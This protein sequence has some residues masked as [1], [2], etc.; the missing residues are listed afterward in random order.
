MLFSVIL[1]ARHIGGGCA[2][3]D[4]GM[5]FHALF[6]CAQHLE[7]G[8]DDPAFDGRL[9]VVLEWVRVKG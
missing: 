7:N 1:S 9:G 2:H 8:A 5:F 6:E 4:Q 3:R